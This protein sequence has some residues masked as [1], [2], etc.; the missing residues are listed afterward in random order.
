M[1]FEYGMKNKRRLMEDKVTILE[2]IDIFSDHSDSSSSSSRPNAIFGVFD[3]KNTM[4]AHLLC[5]QL[6][7]HPPCLFA[8]AIADS[9]RPSM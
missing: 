4:L 2:D 6:A 1:I 3:G 5:V 8:K 9:K 7:S